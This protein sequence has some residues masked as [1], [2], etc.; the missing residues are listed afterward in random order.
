MRGWRSRKRCVM[1]GER[2]SEVG[3]APTRRVPSSPPR[4]RLTSWWSASRSASA[5]CAQPRI[6]SPSGVRPS[7]WRP[8]RTSGMPSSRSRLLTP[9]DSVGWDT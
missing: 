4:R 9:A 5:R 8:R 7:Y 6:R 3:I 1:R 2:G